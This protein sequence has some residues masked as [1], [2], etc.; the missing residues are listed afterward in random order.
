MVKFL[1]N[2][3]SNDKSG[4]EHALEK[5]AIIIDVR[6]LEEFNQ[7]HIKGSKNIPLVEIR[8]RA[9]EIKKWNK[10]IITVCL[11]GSRSAAAKT[12]LATAG[13]EVYNGGSWSQL[14]NMMV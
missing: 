8:Q 5:N 12:V 10:P 7:G 1:K 3:L 13:I 2:L 6:T 9:E 11:S 14:Q 4:I